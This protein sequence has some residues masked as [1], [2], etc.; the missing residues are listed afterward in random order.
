MFY[1]VKQCQCCLFSLN[2]L[3]MTT[4]VLRVLFFSSLCLCFGCFNMFAF[5][6]LLLFNNIDTF[7]AAIILLTVVKKINE[8]ST[9]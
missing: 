4:S 7:I 3:N 1:Q 9:F 8:N 2:K 5:I 6:N